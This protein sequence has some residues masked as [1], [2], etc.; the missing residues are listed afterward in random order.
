M[1]L[2]MHKY[3]KARHSWSSLCGVRGSLDSELHGNT[4][5]P[6]RTYRP[7]TSNVGN[8]IW[9]FG[10]LKSTSKM[11]KVTSPTGK[12]ISLVNLFRFFLL[13]NCF[14]GYM[15]IIKRNNGKVLT[16][17]GFYALKCTGT[18]SSSSSKY[19][20]SLSTRLIGSECVCDLWSVG[21]QETKEKFWLG[22][23]S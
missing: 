22:A 17:N 1:L 6:N 19:E 20:P 23:C 14:A 7:V 16:V 12:A 18:S 5:F 8:P 9:K 15:W 4:K 21:V 10:V 11:G 2:S 13:F 3:L